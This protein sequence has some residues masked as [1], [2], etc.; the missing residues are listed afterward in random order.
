M[1]NYENIEL[2]RR[3]KEKAERLARPFVDRK[4]EEL[5]TL[6]NSGE[7][8]THYLGYDIVKDTRFQYILTL[9]PGEAA[10]G[11]KSRKQNKE[12]DNKEPDYTFFHVAMD[13]ND[14]LTEFK[15]IYSSVIQGKQARFKW[16]MGSVVRKNPECRKAE[17]ELLQA[18]L[19]DAVGAR[20]DD[21]ELN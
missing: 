11:V 13:R 17:Q 9:W 2:F 16:K 4:L 14:R 3:V 19:R 5:L 18:F 8:Q 6:V 1:M 7:H 10:I 15:G 21:F 20:E 12:P